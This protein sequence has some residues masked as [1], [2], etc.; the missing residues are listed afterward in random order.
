MDGVS[1]VDSA[2]DFHYNEIA[3]Q[4]CSATVSTATTNRYSRYTIHSPTTSIQN[5]TNIVTPRLSIVNQPTPVIS[6]IAITPGTVDT[7]SR[8]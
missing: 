8:N 1:A 7:S 2:L 5:P 4:I 6:S 3:S